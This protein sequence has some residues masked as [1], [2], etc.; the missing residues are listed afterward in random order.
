MQ[1]YSCPKCGASA[2]SS[3]SAQMVK[4][5]SCSEPLADVSPDVPV[6]VAEPST[7]PRVELAGRD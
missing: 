1:H 3:A 4:C 2:Y 6:G 5:P 7:Q